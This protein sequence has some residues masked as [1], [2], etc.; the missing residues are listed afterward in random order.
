MF[1]EGE[2]FM[3]L[4]PYLNHA[5]KRY[6]SGWVWFQRNESGEWY[7]LPDPNRGEHSQVGAFSLQEALAYAERVLNLRFELAGAPED[8]PDSY[9][10]PPQW[11]GDPAPSQRLAPDFADPSESRPVFTKQVTGAAAAKLLAEA[12]ALVP[13]MSGVGNKEQPVSPEEPTEFEHWELALLTG[14]LNKRDS[15]FHRSL[16]AITQPETL[17]LALDCIPRTDTHRRTLVEQ[18]MLALTTAATSSAS[19]RKQLTSL[20]H[21][22]PRHL[23]T[24]GRTFLS[25]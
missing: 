14:M 21:Q 18:R 3:V 9:P 15:A 8:L 16:K 4:N 19:Q 11:E 10:L 5:E 12:A 24:L 13:E 6:A 2:H 7:C 20:N 17:R 22:P 1:F 25:P 23:T